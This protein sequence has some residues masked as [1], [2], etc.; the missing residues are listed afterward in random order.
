MRTLNLARFALMIA[1]LGFAAPAFA[2]ETK[3]TPAAAAIP[4]AAP[5][6]PGSVTPFQ[7]FRSGTQSYLAGEKQKAVSELGYAADQGHALAQWKLGRMYAE[8]DGVKRN[9]L[10]AFHYF[11]KLA[12]DNADV[13]PSGAQARFVSN[14]FVAVGTY[15]QTGIP[16]TPVKPDIERAREMYSYAAS[17]FGDPDAQYYLAKLYLDQ[18][19]ARQA[20]R[21]LSLSAQKGQHQA[22]AVLGRLLF[23]GEGGLPR[24]AARGL[25]WLTLAREG[26]AGADDGWIVEYYDDAIAHS[27]EDDRALARVYHQQWVS[28]QR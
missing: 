1:A 16:N 22:Q 17:Y 4:G 27:S 7:A 15:Y 12:M 11:S 24:Q 20:A 23:T 18:K 9:D 28:K 21:W 2:F 25:M 6:V 8:G 10:K 5:A 19:D 14:A 26:A 13:A 3:D